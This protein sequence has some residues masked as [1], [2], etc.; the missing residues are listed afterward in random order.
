[1]EVLFRWLSPALQWSPQ[2]RAPGLRV[3]ARPKWSR[4]AY[5]PRS[6]VSQMR[7]TVFDARLTRRQVKGFVCATSREGEASACASLRCCAWESGVSLQASSKWSV[8]LRKG[9]PSTA[10][11]AAS[12][13]MA[14]STVHAPARS[15]PYPNVCR[16]KYLCHPHLCEY[17]EIVKARH[18][19]QCPT[20]RV[21]RI[22]SVTRRCS[23][24]RTW[25]TRLPQARSC[26]CGLGTPP[27]QPSQRTAGAAVRIPR[28]VP[29]LVHA[30]HAWAPAAPCL[31]ACRPPRSRRAVLWGGGVRAVM[32]ALRCERDDTTGS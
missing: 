15:M 29:Y 27:T 5:A 3:A 17:V 22:A 12:T 9:R 11:S 7:R 14:D 25:L 26:L 18:G 31:L 19:V 6:F 10:S 21:Q 13:G 32:C 20:L 28:R 30:P 16:L 23:S 1:M 8:A 2:W 24:P 4:W